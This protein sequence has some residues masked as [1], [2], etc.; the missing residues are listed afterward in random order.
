MKD[1]YNLREIEKKW[2]KFW[3]KEKLYKF[4]PNSK[5]EIFSVDTPPPTISGEI[6]MGHAFSYPHVDFII[7]YKRM[8]GF[9]VFYPFGFDNNGLP[10]E[11]LVEKQRKVNAL[12]LG[13]EKFI[14]LCLEVSKE[15]EKKFKEIWSDLGLSVDWSLLY[16][17]I[18]KRVQRVSQ[19]SFIELYEKGREYR[20]EVPYMW[21]P[22][23][24]TAI[25]QVE[26]ED[27]EFDSTFNDIVFKVDNKD[28][29]IA[30][31][32]P[33]LLPSCVALFYHPKD[34]RYK[35]Y[36]GKKAK[37]PLFNH[38]VPILEDERADPEKG[39]G[40][41]M[42]CLFGDTTDIE[43]YL[44]YNLPLKVCLTKDG[45]LNKLAGKYEGMKIKE[46]RKAIIDDLKKN[47]LLIK[48][49]PIKHVVNV[50]ERCGTEIE[51]LLTKQWFIKYLDLKSKFLKL[52]NEI[53][54]YPKHMESRYKNWVKGLQWDWCISRQRFY[55]IPIPVWYC[56]KCGEIIL[57]DKKDLPVNP[58]K[59]KPKR[60]CKCGSDEFIPEEDVLD[61]WATSS[62]T[63]QVNCKWNEDDKF[64][65]KMF[66]MDLRASAHDIIAQWQFNTVVK[67]Y[68]HNN[69][70]PWKNIIISG[71]CLDPKGKK[72]SKSKGNIID[73]IKLLE[74]Y[75]AD[76]LRFW[77]ASAGL[78]EDLPFQEKELV[79][80]KRMIVKLINASKF[81]FGHLKGYKLKN[82]KNLEAFDKWLLLKLDKVIELSTNSFEKYEYSKVKSEVE[83]F[84]WNTFCDYYLEIIKDRLYNEEKRGK[85]AKESAQYTLYNSLLTILKLM[86]PIIPHIT[87]EIY[88]NYFEKKS[89]HVSS[90][91]K[92]YNVKGDLKAGEKAIEIISKVRQF[93]TK[94]NKSLKEEVKLVIEKKFEKDLKEFLDDL[95]AVC[96]A[97]ISFGKKFEISFVN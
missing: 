28:L 26:L 25:A 14:K 56:K 81:S 38:E 11:R 76:A 22:V 94:N 3:E 73:P 95:K 84:F 9:N 17:T 50:H 92:K 10:T 65:K 58:L 88:Q 13:R 49:E 6:H 33:E 75:P 27:K 89:I 87:E 77:A 91:P 45:R 62:L 68:L 79:A 36:K 46:A 71:W 1:K 69:S 47:N 57:P 48:Q 20:K 54:W 63:P 61:T 70:I 66:P 96:K 30:T 41:V 8:N 52:S 23:C 51:F 34:K 72:M 39:S 24:Q 55:G 93:K 97:E 64:F 16:S 44:A 83:K 5:K 4:N 86:A 7:R 12:E 78:G 74:D 40:I 37:V 31:T 32:R 90:W 42:C 15:Y 67:A 19:L 60:K 21:C 2:Q 35:K 18:D 85:K 43:W 59:D 82:I 80:G 53:N 29:I